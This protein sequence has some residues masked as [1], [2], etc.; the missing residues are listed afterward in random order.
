MTG[1]ALSFGRFRLDLD[2]RVL[3]RDDEPVQLGSRALDILCVLASAR[4]ALVTKDELMVQV[5]PGTI[6]EE[7][8]IHVHVSALRKALDLGTGG[9]SCILTVPRRGYRLVGFTDLPLPAGKPVSAAFPPLPDKPSIAVVPFQSMSGDLQHEYLSDGIVEEI[10]TA[11]SRCRGLFVIARNSSFTYKG[12]TIDLRQVGRELGVR[13]VLE[14]SI[15]N[16]GGRVRI[17]AQLIEA[18]TGAHLWADRFDCELNDMFDLQDQV[19]ASVA[20]VLEPTLQ[21]AELRRSSTRPT[22]DLSAYDLYLRAY[23]ESRLWERE[24]YSRAA[25]LLAQALKR[26]DRY[27]RALALSAY[28][29]AMLWTGGWCHDPVAS[30]REAVE[31]AHRAIRAVDDDPDVLGRAAYVFAVL[32]EDIGAAMALVD[33]ALDINPNYANGWYYSAWVRLL[34]GQ[35]EVAM[36]HFTQASRLSPYERVRILFGIGLCQ[37]FTGCLDQAKTTLLDAVQEF[38]NWSPNLRVLA[39]CC[40]R[41]GQLDEARQVVDRLRA[42]TPHIITPATQLRDPKQREFMISSLRL[43]AGEP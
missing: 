13:Y 22:S 31:L 8:N 11:L 23:Q 42:I 24:G 20:G 40:A 28:C 41:L 16:S 35:S 29:T 25:E 37:F 7:N 30:S 3:V 32:G 9:P 17:T 36:D 19:A 39:A 21:A 43:A 34:A 4:G 1:S 15:R 33:R 38:P 27:G 12:R 26:D 14:G 10:I 2:R 6:I 18:E 5:W